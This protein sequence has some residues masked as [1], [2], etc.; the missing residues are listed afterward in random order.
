MIPSR[1]ATPSQT[2]PH[3]TAATEFRCPRFDILK[4]RFSQQNYPPASD[5][6]VQV[7]G[8]MLQGAII[9]PYTLGDKIIS[10]IQPA[11]P[12]AWNDMPAECCPY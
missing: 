9:P 10:L 4:T 6:N 7:L 3:N 12:F 8:E 1:A 2:P 5:L 11:K